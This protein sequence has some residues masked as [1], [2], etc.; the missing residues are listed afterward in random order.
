MR[1][2]SNFDGCTRHKYYI[3]LVDPDMIPSP[4]RSLRHLTNIT[5]LSVATRMIGETEDKST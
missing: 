2:D 3:F 4:M 1:L 5:G